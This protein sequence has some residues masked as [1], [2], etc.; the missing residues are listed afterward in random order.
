MSIAGISHSNGDPDTVHWQGDPVASGVCEVS[1]NPETGILFDWKGKN[2]DS[3]K[4]YFFDIHED[5]QKPL[6][7]SGVLDYLISQKN[8]YFEIDSKCQNS[9]MLPKVKAKL[10]ANS[11]LQKGTWAYVGSPSNASERY[12]YWTSLDTN[13]V[14]AGQKIPVIISTADRKYYVAESTTAERTGN[15][16]PYVAISGHLT[17]A[18]YKKIIAKGQEYDSLQAAY[19]AYEKELTDGEYQRYKN[20]LQ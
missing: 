12:F 6:N 3:S 9:S 19:D 20:T 17:Q 11:L 4:K 5:L 7:E 13:A 14:G 1:Y 18:D 8:N 16:P 2:E 15:G 10:Q